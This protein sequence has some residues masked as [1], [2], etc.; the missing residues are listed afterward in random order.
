MKLDA[1]SITFE[2]IPRNGSRYSLVLVEDPNGGCLVIWS[3]AKMLWLYHKGDILK[4]LVESC[5]KFDGAA[6]F[7]FL[8]DN[9]KG[10]IE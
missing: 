5:N 10:D 8:E 2:P 9:S 1:I 3:S 7:Q 4:P 6:I